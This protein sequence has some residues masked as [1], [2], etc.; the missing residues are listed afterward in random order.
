[1]QE[2]LSTPKSIDGLL[3]EINDLMSTQAD[4]ISI[5]R[6][7]VT[8]WIPAEYWKKYDAIQKKSRGKFHKVIRQV[9]MRAIDSIQIEDADM[10]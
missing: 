4:V 3:G 10:D 7:S 8:V 2:N 1:M 6:K 5:D 9:M